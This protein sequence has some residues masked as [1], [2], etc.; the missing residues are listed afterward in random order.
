M[1][2]RGGTGQLK[3]HIGSTIG[4][5]VAAAAVLVAAMSVG[6]M[7]PAG[8]DEIS[9]DAM[10]WT[11]VWS[12]PPSDASRT[13]DITSLVDPSRNPL[14][15]VSNSTVRAIV[16]PSTGGSEIRVHL[17]N[18]FGSE[19]VTFDHVT[20][21]LQKN[22]PALVGGS[23]T[24][25]RF[26]G[27]EA[28]TAA[29]GDDVASDP[30]GFSFE[31][32]QSLAVSIFVAGDAGK[33]TIHYTARQTS[34][35]TLPQGGNHTTDVEGSALS[36]ATTS[37][38]FLTGL[39]V[40]TTANVGTVV[41]F[42]D[43]TT[44]GY[45][46]QARDRGIETEEGLDQNERYPDYLAERLRV[47]GEPLVVV[48]AG[49]TGNRLL[50]DGLD[51]GNRARN[52][53]SAAQRLERDV[54]GRAGVTTVI[55][56]VGVNDLGMTPQASADELAA[57]YTELIGSLH[58][59]DLTVLH[60]TLTPAGGSASYGTQGLEAERQKVNAWIRSDSPADGIVDFDAAV[61]DPADPT[62][63]DPS[64][65]GGDHLHMSPAGNQAM[66][67]AVDLGDLRPATCAVV[68]SSDV[69]AATS[70]P[71]KALWIVVLVAV[72]GVTF[73]VLRR[74]PRSVSRNS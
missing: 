73:V 66:A 34:Y 32:G 19:P 45:Q 69:A 7:W 12:G 33:P 62:R 72:S 30:V 23:V 60:G 61:R 25:V 31:T 28:V 11:A 14:G 8:A 22:G 17:S 70:G 18:R 42:G 71:G 57:G 44:D 38:P 39:D 21:A 74:V 27:E 3:P 40:R 47:A 4:R 58:E 43:S 51:G 26:G 9:C 59:A 53:S 64:F 2:V 67:A 50:R 65:D 13:E 35:L 46:G 54:L 10:Q 63:L 36:E 6:S 16:T 48:N 52:G 49:I 20:V 41:A 55:L 37:R 56:L 24:Q 29:A 68:A 1:S 15:R 5:L